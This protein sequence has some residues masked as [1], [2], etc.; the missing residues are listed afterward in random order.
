MKTDMK[1]RILSLCA[2]AAFACILY[3]V[4]VK[5]QQRQ[6]V[7]IDIGRY[8]S[9]QAEEKAALHRLSVELIKHPEAKSIQIVAGPSPWRQGIM[10]F[11]RIN[12]DGNQNIF[13]M[14]NRFFSA[15]FD[16]KLHIGIHA[17]VLSSEEPI[18]EAASHL[19]TFQDVTDY[20]EQLKKK[21]RMKQASIPE[22]S[23]FFKIVLS[24]KATAL[25]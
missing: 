16:P 25:N 1:K 13:W 6:I 3:L 14:D 10:G 21:L 23:N 20:D 22:N 11:T 8:T 12:Q 17:T 24:G 7:T 9:P 18:H 5:I 4:Y 19:A 2:L 15:V